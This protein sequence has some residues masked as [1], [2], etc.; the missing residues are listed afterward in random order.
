VQQS[1]KARLDWKKFFSP[2]ASALLLGK[3]LVKIKHSI[4]I[5]A[6]KDRVWEIISDL[7]NEPE[8]WYGTKDT[9]TISRNGNVVEREITQNFRNHKILQKAVLHPKNSVEIQYLKGL[10]MGSKIISIEPLEENKQRL[11]VFWDIHFEGIYKL[12]TPMIKGHT[13]KGTIGALSRIKQVAELQSGQDSTNKEAVGQ[14][15]KAQPNT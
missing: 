13:E 3:K 9:R 10:T 6:S 11:N 12:A 7:E 4:E 5:N 2:R 14:R 15:E 8:Y 1:A